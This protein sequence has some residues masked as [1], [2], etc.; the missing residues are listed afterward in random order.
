MHQVLREQ[1]RLK[2]EVEARRKKRLE[3]RPALVERLTAEDL[4]RRFERAERA[5]YKAMFSDMKKRRHLILDSDDM[6]ADA[7]KERRMFK[8]MLANEQADK[9]EQKKWE[10]KEAKKSG[11]EKA[12]KKDDE[13]EKREGGNAL[14]EYMDELMKQA[15]AAYN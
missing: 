3:E 10:R 14:N 7:L 2:E 9:E 11:G 1:E 15:N 8:T 4:A 5:H 6:S 12:K 13:G